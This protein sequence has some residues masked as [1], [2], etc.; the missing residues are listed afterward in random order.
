MNQSDAR[1][2]I[3]TLESQVFEMTQRL[4]QLRRQVEPAE[5]PNY[6]FETLEGKATL[7]E[8]F[9]GRDRLV[10]IHNMG[11]GCRYC[12]LWA[13][14]FNGFL[15][16]LENATA[17]VV[18][19]KDNP[20]TQ[21]LFANSRNWRFRMASHGGGAYIKEQSAVPGENNMPGLATYIRK[22][23]K[24]FR[25]NGSAFGPGDQFCSIWHV[26]S[27]AGIDEA[28]WTPQFNY[29]QRPGKLDDGGKNVLG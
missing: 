16:H 17:F 5:V 9:A 7:L 26:L 25:L 8:L 15:P 28:E 3:A 20:E 27:A 10:V 13:D 23:E 18:V 29:W 4:H 14:G 2:Q 22:G 19:S 1:K 6:S 11:Q 21:R 24:V 12:T